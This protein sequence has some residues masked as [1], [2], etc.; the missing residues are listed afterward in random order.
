MVPSLSHNSDGSGSQ[1]ESST[2]DDM[3]DGPLTAPSV[4]RQGGG[5]QLT[6]HGSMAASESIFLR[7]YEHGRLAFETPVSLE[8]RSNME[9]LFAVLRREEPGMLRRLLLKAGEKDKGPGELIFK[10]HRSYDIM[11]NL[12]L[13]IQYSVGKINTVSQQM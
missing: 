8:D 13:G 12:Q 3:S 7:E 10:E 2:G 5:G 1:L 9:L 4:I 11:V 6:D